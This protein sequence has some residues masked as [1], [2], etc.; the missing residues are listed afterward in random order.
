[1]VAEV[2]IITPIRK[3][4]LII[5][6]FNTPIDWLKEGQG[7]SN[8]SPSIDRM[9]PDLG[10]VP[11]NVRIVSQKANRLKQKNIELKSNFQRG[12]L[13][14]KSA[15]GRAFRAP[16]FKSITLKQFLE[17]LTTRGG[18]PSLPSKTAELG[19]SQKPS[20]SACESRPSGGE[21]KLPRLLS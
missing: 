12:N 11:G 3:K 19:P 17:Q 4:I 1:M 9:K 13:N 16:T 15:D 20:S 7:P 14:F 2:P 18:Q 8:D 6:L 21:T 10:Y 5:D